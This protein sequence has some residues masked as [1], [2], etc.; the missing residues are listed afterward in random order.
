M[1]TILT[2]KYYLNKPGALREAGET[3]KTI[4]K[5]VYIVGGKTALSVSKAFVEG[6]DAA[7]IAYDI[8]EYGGYPTIETAEE[9]ARNAKE[10]EAGAIVGIG[11]GRI[12]DTV[13][14]AGG[15]AGLPVIA[16]PTIA[17]TC[18]SWAATSILYND[19]G[20]FTEPRANEN[21]PIFLV[22][23]TDII[24]N[25]PIRYIQA[26]ISDALARWYENAPHL[27]YSNRFYLR[28]QI[29]QA[30]LIRD[31]LENE[32][33]RVVADLKRGVYDPE[34]VV[35]V[36][37]ASVLLTGLFVSIRSTDELFYGGIAHNIYHLSSPLHELHGALHGEQ[38]A[39][40]LIVSALL[41]KKPEKEVLDLVTLFHKFEQPLTLKE[42]GLGDDAP[43]R[44]DKVLPTIY[45]ASEE[46]RK[47]ITQ[48][49]LKELKSTIFEADTIGH[50]FQNKTL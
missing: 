38:I 33:L 19:Q 40:A 26:G 18:A 34:S 13:K 37:D 17:A 16:V 1:T 4:A 39:F 43:E 5:R 49:T 47:L 8:L 25:A 42:I 3:I 28:W 32:G 22:L 46:Y 45:A 2:P 14:A 30:E 24:A 41:E 12:M 6:L 20:E 29:K 31:I 27:R 23:D 9:V 48:F 11:G 36:L 21:A 7:G 44:L 50:A 15:I 10:E 35:T